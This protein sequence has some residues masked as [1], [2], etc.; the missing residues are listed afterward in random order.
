MTP[1]QCVYEESPAVR[2]LDGVE[3]RS[4]AQVLHP[5]RDR[6][7]ISNRQSAQHQPQYARRV[8][9][10]VAVL[11]SKVIEAARLNG[12]VD[13]APTRLAARYH[14]DTVSRSPIQYAL[15]EFDDPVGF[16]VDCFKFD[17][18]G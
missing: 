7:K 10:E 13:K 5:I 9:V 1:V 17:D 3:T 6:E 11:P 12:L 14:S 4:I 16:G 8:R 2:I 18:T 15:A